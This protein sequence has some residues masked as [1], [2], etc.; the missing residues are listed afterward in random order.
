[1]TLKVSGIHMGPG[2]GI[3][4]EV[5]PIVEAHQKGVRISGTLVSIQSY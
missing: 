4:T 1:M 3:V 2:G 5:D